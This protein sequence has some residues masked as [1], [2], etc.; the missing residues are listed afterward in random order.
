M[1]GF[2]A[3]ITVQ[4]PTQEQV[5]AWLRERIVVAYVSPTHHTSTVIYHED[6]GGQES[7]A[8]RLSSHFHCPA[9]LVMDYGG[10]V[11]LYQL[12]VAGEQAD[13]YVSRPCDELDTGGEAPPEGDAATLCEAFGMEHVVAR[14]ERIL[15]RPTDPAKGYAL[16]VNR[17]GELAQALRL[18]LFAAGAGFA[19][20]EMGELPAGAGFDPAGMAR[21]K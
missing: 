20:I 21:T 7:L 17:H 14:V 3:N 5:V 1:S 10:K 18:P 11:L 2:Y 19:S 8:A 13:A 15:R 9:L 16:A 6:L 12:Y 4:G